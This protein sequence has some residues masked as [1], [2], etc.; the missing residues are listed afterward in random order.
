ML[1]GEELV[2]AK[3]L[4]FGVL[5]PYRRRGI[6]RALQ[7]EALQRTRAQGCYQLR[8]HS[9]GD[10]LKNHQLNLSMGFGVHPVVRGA[11]R[12]GVYFVLPLRTHHSSQLDEKGRQ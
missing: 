10:H 5:A 9:G 11:D 7:Q 8:S 3:V 12:H 2:E 4:A 1:C 6:G